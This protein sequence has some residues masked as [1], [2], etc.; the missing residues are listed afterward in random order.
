MLKIGKNMIIVANLAKFKAVVNTLKLITFW[1]FLVILG[2]CYL[3]FFDLK[4][5]NDSNC[6]RLTKADK[7]WQRLTKADNEAPAWG[8]REA[9]QWNGLSSL[10]WLL[11]GKEKRFE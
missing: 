11:N 6:Q 3:S 9:A 7:G 10:H 5:H 4:V 8:F 1:W 2:D